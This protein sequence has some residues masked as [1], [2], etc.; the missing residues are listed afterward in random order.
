MENRSPEPPAVRVVVSRLS[1]ALPPI[2][3]IAMPYEILY[4]SAPS[5][6]KPGSSGYCTVKSSRGIPAPAVDLLE[7]LSGYRH[8]FTPGSPEAARN[9][10]NWGH[11][12]L[13]IS[14]RTEHVLS[15]VSDCELDYTG[16]SNK[17]AHHMV[18]DAS[19]PAGPA[20]LVGQPGWMIGQWDGQLEQF[21]TV[22]KAPPERRAAGRCAAW[23]AATGDAGWGGVL[24]ESFLADPE[25]K[26]FIIYRP[27]QHI[28][29]LIE[30][31]IALLPENRRWEVTFATY[32]AALPKT[33]ECAWTG[34][35]AG[36][37]EVQQS[38]RFVNALRIDLTAPMPRAQGGT[39]VELARTGR[40]SRP[41]SPTS[42][43]VGAHLL[44]PVPTA[45]SAESLSRGM[46]PPPV[47]S[48][49]DEPDFVEEAPPELPQRRKESRLGTLLL[50]TGAISF[51]LA[52][53]VGA[54]AFVVLRNGIPP[55][56]AVNDAQPA[57][58]A[59]APLET[60]MES[61]VGVASENA[62][63]DSQQQNQNG[64]KN[65][66]SE[67]PA[68]PEPPSVTTET[69]KAS[70]GGRDSTS[71]PPATP[72]VAPMATATASM[73]SGK[74]AAATEGSPTAEPASPAPK[75]AEPAPPSGNDSL[76]IPEI[77]AVAEP[78]KV[79]PNPDEF[80]SVRMSSPLKV[81]LQQIAD[82]E[83]FLPRE[84][85]S[86]N[87]LHATAKQQFDSGELMLLPKGAT[88]NVGSEAYL[89]AKT[90]INTDQSI[91]LSLKFPT[92]LSDSNRACIN[93]G[94]LQLWDTDRKRSVLIQLTPNIP[95][96]RAEQRLKKLSCRLTIPTGLKFAL[97]HIRWEDVYVD[98][99]QLRIRDKTIQSTPTG[100]GQLSWDISSF[101]AGKFA[102][103]RAMKN[104][105]TSDTVSVHFTSEPDI[106]TVELQAKAAEQELNGIY[107]SMR[108]I[109]N[110]ETPSMTLKVLHPNA[111]EEFS[112]EDVD[113]SIQDVIAARRRICNTALVAISD[114]MAK[115]TLEV[116][117]DND[118]T[119]INS[120]PQK[121]H[122]Y[123]T[124]KN[125]IAVLESEVAVVSGDVK[126]RATRVLRQPADSKSPEKS[127]ELP[128]T[129]WQFSESR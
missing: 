62:A 73:A 15:R 129:L 69:A 38:R 111:K 33:V 64:N 41:H 17:L 43:R 84:R 92:K 37:P 65:A 1:S 103:L 10:V 5:G 55:L 67:K 124:A 80:Y 47:P 25:R 66:P 106:S 127:Q 49:V 114:A 86:S 23:E 53:C 123:R 58:S 89:V 28:L 101:T 42:S 105:A 109:V 128:I 71:A 51:V 126:C 7:S 93:L 59:D 8:V 115:K 9:P 117:R 11:Y 99:I 107:N 24:A 98:N 48:L 77:V 29:P 6:L 68:T 110:S 119:V 56:L 12:F 102:S 78:L 21:A 18:I 91:A 72:N 26:V 90:H 2:G 54:V 61:P 94:V 52:A 35:V 104:H 60:G 74:A 95:T 108:D 19:C 82:A 3:M 76:Q 63:V 16:R 79:K 87:E 4:T 27:D 70:G 31:A 125:A 36:S 96:S 118:I 97:G 45:A 122:D 100:T 46:V 81:P 34:V 44:P 30:E 57:A 13:R 88:L 20:W 116:A 50:V 22:R 85:D 121:R 75:T 40:T 14:G 39:L 120:Y 83:L 112:E 32:G 113:K